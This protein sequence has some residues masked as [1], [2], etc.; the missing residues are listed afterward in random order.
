MNFK[1]SLLVLSFISSNFS[2]AQTVP[3][4]SVGNPNNV[5]NAVVQ[6]V[7]AALHS[8]SRNDVSKNALSVNCTF[9][10]GTCNGAEVVLLRGENEVFK[11]T[12]TSNGSFIIPNL[13]KHEDYILKLTWKKHDVSE[14]KKVMSGEHVDIVLSKDIKDVVKDESISE[15]KEK[16]KGEK[17]ALARFHLQSLIVRKYSSINITKDL[18]KDAK[19]SA[20]TLLSESEK[21]KTD[22]N[23]GNA[24][25]QSHLVY[26]RLNLLEGNVEGAKKELLLASQ[27]KGS[28]QLSSFGPN[29]TLAKELLEKGEKK[30][31]IEYIDNTLSF[32]TYKT[33]KAKT[34][35]WKKE[36]ESG[37]IPNFGGNLVY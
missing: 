15:L 37:K 19:Q 13:K 34:D 18:I 28:P 22:W 33:A 12:L 25:H 17:D 32:W 9:R 2:F 31:V 21:F 14:I 11:T 7:F 27:T 6:S 3:A 23:F 35:L 10:G 4:S 26:G 16:I 29:M 1:I 36:I 30:A 5:P 8:L 20:D 24:L